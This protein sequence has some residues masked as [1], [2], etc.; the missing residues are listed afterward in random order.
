MVRRILAASALTAALLISG[1]TAAQA[2]DTQVFRGEGHSGF[3][4]EFAYQYAR[5]DALA[6]AR[7][8]GFDYEDCQVINVDDH[9][10]LVVYVDLQCEH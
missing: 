6:Q 9:W 2:A 7:D 1:T 4:P 8:V 10:P 5:A 3:G